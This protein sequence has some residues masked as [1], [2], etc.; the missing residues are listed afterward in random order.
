MLF[1]LSENVFSPNFSNKRHTVYDKIK[2]A[3]GT[4][5]IIINVWTFLAKPRLRDYKTTFNVVYN[6]KIFPNSYLTCSKYLLLSLSVIKSYQY[7]FNNLSMLNIEID[8]IN[9]EDIINIFKN[10]RK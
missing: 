1:N 8:I 6:G 10:N 7:M 5:F 9:Y 4:E 2:L 3:I